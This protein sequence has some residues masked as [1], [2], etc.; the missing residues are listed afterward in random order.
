[1]LDPSFFSSSCSIS[2][3]IWNCPKAVNHKRNTHQLLFSYI[4]VFL[5][6]GSQLRVL[7]L[8]I[9]DLNT[10]FLV[11]IFL[12]AI[13]FLFVNLALLTFFATVQFNVH[14]TR[15]FF[16]IAGVF[17]QIT[18]AF[19]ENVGRLEFLTFSF[20]GASTILL[21]EALESFSPDLGFFVR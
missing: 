14:I 16:V 10:L 1:M 2:R 11:L 12:F 4:V 3:A 17:N 6:I 13:C 18:V 5:L 7:F 8:L 21:L 19:L 15:V 9:P 20:V